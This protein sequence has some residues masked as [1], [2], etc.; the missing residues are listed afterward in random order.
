MAILI[1]LVG[2]YFMLRELIPL[3]NAKRTGVIRT[4]GHTRKRIERSVDPERF[5]GLCRQRFQGMG[6]GLVII[7]LGVLWLLIGIWALIP[8]LIVSAWAAARARK[9]KKKAVADE[10][11]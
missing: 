8:A 1:A 3:L 11:A 4:R 10:F 7:G 2:L 9:P 6:L 5:E